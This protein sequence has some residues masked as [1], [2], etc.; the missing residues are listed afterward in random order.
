MK[1][2]NFFLKKLFIHPTPDRE[3]IP[4]FYMTGS[5]EHCIG[6]IME[7]WNLK[8]SQMEPTLAIALYNKYHTKLHLQK[9]LT[10]QSKAFL[11]PL[12]F[13]FQNS[14]F[15]LKSL[16]GVSIIKQA[17]YS[18]D[19]CGSVSACHSEIWL[20]VRRNSICSWNADTTYSTPPTAPKPPSKRSSG[21]PGRRCGC[22]WHV[23]EAWCRCTCANLGP[24]K[25]EVDAGV[26]RADNRGL[27]GCRGRFASCEFFRQN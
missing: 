5:S 19:V 20:R 25:L 10:L 26:W 24:S 7:S 17:F 14:K 27:R 3:P 12:V 16:D 13:V 9:P 23:L 22:V 2:I 6:S 21:E 11:E 15:K 4:V 18:T 1:C 8:C